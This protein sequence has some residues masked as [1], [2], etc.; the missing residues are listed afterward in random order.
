MTFR[1]KLLGIVLM[2]A[3]AGPACSLGRSAPPPPPAPAPAVE[4]PASAEEASSTTTTEPSL[5]FAVPEP[6]PPAEVAD[7]FEN[8]DLAELY[9]ESPEAAL[10][11]LRLIREAAKK[12]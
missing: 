6:A 8:P 9:R 11:L 12:K 4:E 3:A 10:D 5:V 2:L 7:P 1:R